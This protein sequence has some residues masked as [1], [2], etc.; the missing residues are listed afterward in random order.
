MLQQL[1]HTTFLRKRVFRKFNSTFFCS[2]VLQWACLIASHY[3]VK[4]HSLGHLCL[5][6]TWSCRKTS[7]EACPVHTEAVT[8]ASLSEVTVPLGKPTK[9]AYLVA[10]RCASQ[11]PKAFR[12]L[13]RD[14]AGPPPDA[15]HQ[16]SAHEAQ[17]GGTASTTALLPLTGGAGKSQSLLTSSTPALDPCFPYRLCPVLPR[18]SAV[19]IHCSGL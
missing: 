12:Q 7:S 9:A 11:C 16:T 6:H 3:V 10:T 15:K 8:P 17:T 14:G 1:L 13:H 18:P 2:E 5:S 4:D 19:W